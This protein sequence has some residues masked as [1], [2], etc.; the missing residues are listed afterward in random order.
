MWIVSL[1]FLFL[2]TIFG[3][4]QVA[5][6][7][8]LPQILATLIHG[9]YATAFEL[10]A[11][12]A[13]ILFRLLAPFMG[14]WKGC[15]SRIKRSFADNRPIL[16]SHGIFHDSSAFIFL[17]PFLYWRGFRQV[18]TINFWPPIACSLDEYAKMLE[19]RARQ[20][21]QKR[22]EEEGSCKEIIFLGH[23]M[24]GLIE[25]RA[26]LNLACQK[27]FPAL[28]KVIT[29]GSPLKGS[30]AAYIAYPLGQHARDMVPGSIF[31]KRLQEDLTKPLSEQ[32]EFLEIG[33]TMDQLVSIDS[34]CLA[35]NVSF[36][37]NSPYKRDSVQIKDLGHLSLLYSPKIAKAITDWLGC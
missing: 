4:N 9:L 20:M 21:V 24:G 1:P 26:A 10:L 28:I 16:C 8:K 32:I 22:I 5:H 13:Q 17:L 12:I 30:Q 19:K 29:L 34:A 2:G 23:S 37:K 31:L 25:T 7:G 36:A 6:K 27:D 3:L 15:V 18:A 33:S 35:R 14:I 11:F